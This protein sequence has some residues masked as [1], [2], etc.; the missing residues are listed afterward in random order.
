MDR[1]HFSRILGG[2]LGASPFCWKLMGATSSLGAS[3]VPSGPVGAMSPSATPSP[4]ESL[5]QDEPLR[6][7]G[8]R[9][10]GWIQE[11]ARFGARPEGGLDRVAFSDADLEARKYVR[12][13]MDETGLA[14]RMDVAGNLFG[15]LQGGVGSLP[16]LMVGSHVDSVPAGGI[17]DGPL[18]VLSALECARRLREAGLRPRHSIDVAVFVNEEGG[19]T[20]SRV[21]AGEFR[22]Q[23]LELES[24]SG[25]TIREGI[26]RLG[27]DPDRL[28]EARV[29]PGEVAGFLELHIEQ[30]AVLERS[31]TSIGVVEGIVGI[32]RWNAVIHG[33]AN[34]AGTTPMNQRRDALLG[35]ARLVEAVNR[36]ANSLS[37]SQVATVG[38]IQAEPG[39]P[40]V[41]PGRVT[42]SIEIRALEME[43]IQEVMDGIEEEA[44]RIETENGTPIEIEEFYLS[45]GA[46]TDERF[47]AWVEEA[48][49]DLGLSHRRMPSGAGH[50]AQAVA[51]FAPV[52]MV[53]IPSVGGL[54]HHPDEYSRPE[55]IEAGGNVLLGALMKADA[56]L[57]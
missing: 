46:P 39:A 34:H 52:G 1:R 36:V 29:G 24:A 55:D 16:P 20:G 30:G 50:D 19:K 5:D 15:R 33:A 47:R 57:D 35:G 54:S 18:G 11:M 28:E 4:W 6:I 25:F 49:S 8:E 27:G 44:R 23:E 51:H 37:G 31:G 41:I 53:F 40:N 7:D 3:T 14:V 32:R 13:L 48:A 10:N 42:L 56:G 26:R 9:L 45:A 43:R 21:M 17:Y 22:P 38:R 2:A 12:H